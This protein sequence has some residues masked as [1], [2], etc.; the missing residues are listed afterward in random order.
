MFQIVSGAS[1]ATRRYQTAVCRRHRAKRAH[2]LLPMIRMIDLSAQCKPA[3]APAPRKAG[4]RHRGIG[5]RHVAL[6]LIAAIAI[7][8]WF[9]ALPALL[10]KDGLSRSMQACGTPVYRDPVSGRA[11]THD[12]RASATACGLTARDAAR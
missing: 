6:A 12:G 1:M 5:A 3:F 2:H 10:S 8:G 4:A 9:A 7:A 11:L